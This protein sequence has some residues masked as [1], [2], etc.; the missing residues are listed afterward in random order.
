MKRKVNESQKQTMFLRITNF[1]VQGIPWK[2]CS[3]LTD[4]EILALH[5]NLKFHYHFHNNLLLDTNL[6]QFNL[7]HVFWILFL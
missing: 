1:I 5:R 7:V 2:V 6:S 4:Q 3:Q